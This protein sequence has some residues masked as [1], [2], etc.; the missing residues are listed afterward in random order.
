MGVN[1][2][3]NVSYL[4]YAV[5]GI[6]AIMAVV[7]FFALD[8]PK[9][10]RMVTGRYTSYR[11]CRKMQQKTVKTAPRNGAA[12]KKLGSLP[13]ERISKSELFAADTEIISRSRGVEMKEKPVCET[14]LPDCAGDQGTELPGTIGLEMIQDI[15]YMPDTTEIS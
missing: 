14:V 1:N 11:D 4:L 5:S 3:I 8:I 9:C 7:L 13:T 10:W 6:S 15:V 2:M 12:T